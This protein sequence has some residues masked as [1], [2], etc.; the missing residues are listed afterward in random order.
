MIYLAKAKD[1][2]KDQLVIP[3]KRLSVAEIM[4]S[5]KK[6]FGQDV[7][8]VDDVKHIAK[9]PRFSS[10]ITSLDLILGGG[11]PIGRIIEIYGPESSGKTTIALHAIKSAQEKGMTCA[12]IDAEHAHDAV[13]AH[14]LG[15]DTSQLLL[16][17][18]IGGEKALAVVDALVRTGSVGLIVVDSVA[19]L[20]PE[21]E[22]D[23]E[24]GDANVGLHAR[25][26]SQAMRKLTG[27]AQAM[28]CTIIFI[29]QIREKVGVMFGSPETTTGG[30]AL[31]FYAS[32]RVDVRRKETLKNGNDAYA[33]HV[34]VKTVKNKTFPPMKQAE[35]DVIFGKGVDNTGS[36]V[37][38]AVDFGIM[39]KGGGGYYTY[40]D[41]LRVQGRPKMVEYLNS[42]EGAEAL[43]ALQTEIEEMLSQ[44]SA[45]MMNLSADE[46]AKTRAQLEGE[47]EADAI[48]EQAAKDAGV[49]TEENFGE[50]A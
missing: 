10:G 46:F 16:C 8:T 26:M 33:N 34:V 12:Y 3:G 29:N 47:E 15:V 39:T 48:A 28:N 38:L 25:L 5:L 37:D 6:D 31:K 22:L 49:D 41:G 24:F 44:D 32:I 14:N 2:K 4:S 20:V 11:W 17:N 19:A 1:K 50:V 7:L 40:G 43:A 13:Y 18:E 23:G 21:K 45:M 35:F 27:P 30:R 36:L 9:I 42:P